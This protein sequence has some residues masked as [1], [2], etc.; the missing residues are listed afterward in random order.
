[1]KKFLERI[2][3]IISVLIFRYQQFCYA[4]VITIDP[5]EEIKPIAFLIGFIGVIILIISAISYFCL[6]ATIK[7]Q[8]KQKDDNENSKVCGSEKIENKNKLIQKIIYV[9]VIIVTISIFIYWIIYKDIFTR[10]FFIPIILFFVSIIV[11]LNKKKKISNIIYIISMVIICL[12][13]I[14]NSMVEDYN[15]KF[16]QYLE[17]D[18]WSKIEY[19]PNKNIEGLINTTIENNKSGRKTTIIYKDVSYTS[20]DELRKLLNEINTDVAYSFIM[21]RKSYNDYID[22]ITLIPYSESEEFLVHFRIYEGDK[23]RG[24]KIK[25]LIEIA[26]QVAHKI[27]IIYT[28]EIGEKVR[29]ELNTNNAE[30]LKDEIMEDKTYKVEIQTDSSDVCNIIITS[31]N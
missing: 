10:T 9:L 31:N 11:R 18:S 4:D 22:A 12:I 29:V 2:L 15:N 5:V 26:M 20:P 16:F 7:K 1:M 28:S 17:A 19:L 14:S 3:G 6:K 21:K 25:D 13:G 23:I 27:N 24:K 30:S 8:D